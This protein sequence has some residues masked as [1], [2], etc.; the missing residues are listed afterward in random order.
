MRRYLKEKAYQEPPYTTAKDFYAQIKR[1][2]PDSLKETVS[3]LFERIVVFDNK[4]RN[5]TVQKT[6][7]QYKVTMLVN[8]GKT[9]SDSLGKAKEAIVNDWIDIGVFAKN[10]ENNAALGKELI[11][12][13]YKITGKEQKIEFT[14]PVEP[15][16]VGIDPYNKLIDLDPDDNIKTCPKVN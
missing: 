8:A 11:F 12:K 13:K 7:K 4:V 6:D 16:M 5:V 15:Y 3:D 2:T 10:E 1:S 9:K 14:L